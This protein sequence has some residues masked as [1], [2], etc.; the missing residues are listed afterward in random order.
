MYE[1]TVC[2]TFSAAHQ[3]PNTG[4]HCERLHGHNWKVEVRVA[5][6]ELDASGMVLDF[7]EVKTALRGLLED[8]DHQFLNDLPAFRCS[9]PTAENLAKHI[10]E[11][12]AG[13]LS[14]PR[15]RLTRVTVWESEGT[16]ASYSVSSPL[17]P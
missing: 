14:P 7:H 11:G 4:G 6:E 10:H 13:R 12:L 3:L 9:L 8:L 15:V 2:G 16:A 5:A 1:L 17:K